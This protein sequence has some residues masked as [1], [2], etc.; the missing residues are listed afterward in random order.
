MQGDTAMH[1]AINNSL[2]GCVGEL[3]HKTD[4]DAMTDKVRLLLAKQEAQPCLRASMLVL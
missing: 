4:L 3:A 2:E 1:L